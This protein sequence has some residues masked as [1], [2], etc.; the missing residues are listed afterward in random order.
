MLFGASLVISL[1]ESASGINSLLPLPGVKIGF[2]NIA[3]CAC[4]YAVSVK[5]AFA[6]SVL[7]P[8]LLFFLSGNPVSFAM[9][10]FGSLLSFL[11]LVLTKPLYNKLYSFAGIS[12]ISAVFHSVGQTLAAMLIMRD[13]ALMLYL[14]LFVA[15]SSIV[16]T[17]CGCVMN[18][19][20]PRLCAVYGRN[21]I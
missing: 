12:C 8:I 9:S 2:C 14:P 5:G 6:I 1:V 16:G 11:S 18:L 7:R 15:S 10:I 17:A 3:A 19:I 4:F 21:E 20:I 13:G